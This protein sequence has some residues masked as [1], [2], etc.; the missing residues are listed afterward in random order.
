M[1]SAG[2]ISRWVRRAHPSNHFGS[3]ENGKYSNHMIGFEL[4]LD[5]VCPVADESRAIACRV[6]FPATQS[7]APLRRQPGCPKLV[8]S[9]QGAMNGGGFKKHCGWQK[10]TGSGTEVRV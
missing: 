9:L 10:Q 1:R 7:H 5:P 6:T 4:Q 8:S 2:A 3:L